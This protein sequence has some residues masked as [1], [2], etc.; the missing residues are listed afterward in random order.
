MFPEA[1][2]QMQK[3][4]RSDFIKQLQGTWIHEED[5]NAS[6]VVKV[7]SWT[8]TYSGDKRTAD[9]HYIISITD[10]LPQFADKN[11]KARFLVLTQKADTLH[12]EILGLTDKSLSLMHF[13]SGK[14]HLYKKRNK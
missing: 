4:F 12:Y 5:K 1:V 13:P 9:D 6:I 11:D 7:K 3:D 2:M 8:F 14:R 10:Q